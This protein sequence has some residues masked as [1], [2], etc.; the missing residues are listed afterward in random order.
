MSSI[1]PIQRQATGRV[2]RLSKKSRKMK[3]R[4]NKAGF[5]SRFKPANWFR[6]FE[7]ISITLEEFDY[8]RK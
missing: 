3:N 8:R 2:V 6:E 5:F 1:I 7:D 4:H